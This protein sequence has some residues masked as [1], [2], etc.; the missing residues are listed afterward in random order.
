[1]SACC[2]HCQGLGGSIY[3]AQ[4]QW[5]TAASRLPFKDLF[6]KD[7]AALKRYIREGG[8]INAAGCDPPHLTLLHAACGLKLSTAAHHLVEAGADVNATSGDGI[9]PLMVVQTADAARLLLDSGADIEQRDH[10]GLNA[11]ARACQNGNL[12]VVKVLL[13][14]GSAASV[15][16]ACCHGFTPLSAAI[17]SGNEALA[18]LVL[19]AHPA[20]YNGNEELQADNIDTTLYTATGF[21]FMKL[22]E[23]LLKRG[24]DVNRGCVGEHDRTPYMYA[25]QEGNLAMLDLL[26]QYGADVNAVSSDGSSAMFAAIKGR[27]LAVKRLLKHGFDVNV[28]VSCE[29][30]ATPLN[31]A[32]MGGNLSVIKSTARLWGLGSLRAQK[33][34]L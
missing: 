20:D 17:Y 15:T 34:Q 25:A 27:V 1:M 3:S 19:A 14:R 11:L 24:A 18:L 4:L 5:Q 13:K 10:K 26:Q 28:K 16:H 30:D 32:V 31:N 33:R 7:C 6:N 23:A 21:G 9:T 22:A 12:E 8:D 2:P 29:W